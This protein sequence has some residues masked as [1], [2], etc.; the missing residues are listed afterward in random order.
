MPAQVIIHSIKLM[1]NTDQHTSYVKRGKTSL[2]FS[3]EKNKCIL[4]ECVHMCVYCLCVSVHER[5]QR[6]REIVCV[7]SVCVCVWKS[8]QMKHKKAMLRTGV[9]RKKGLKSHVL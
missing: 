7:L 6:E 2:E 1:I 5:G 3:E 4:S 8:V 9:G